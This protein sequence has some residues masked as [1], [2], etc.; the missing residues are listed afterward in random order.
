MWDDYQLRSVQLGGNKALF[1][2]MKEY[3]ITDL[4]FAKK[5]N[6]KAIKWYITKHKSDMDGTIMNTVKPAK[7]LKESA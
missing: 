5:Y 6:H 7:T 2:I 4:D 3:E 1:E